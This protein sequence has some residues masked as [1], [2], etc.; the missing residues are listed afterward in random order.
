MTRPE[1]MVAKGDA[2]G[3]ITFFPIAP[4]MHGATQWSVMG[5]AF[6]GRTN[7]LMD[8]FDPNEVWRLVEAEKV[9]GLMITGDAMG[10]PLVE[11]LDAGVEYD[12]SSLALL[13]SSAA[14]FSQTVKDHFFDHFENL[15]IIDSIGSSESGNN[16]MAML[17]KGSGS[18]KGGGPTV[19]AGLDAHVFDEDLKPVEP[20]SGV[21]GKIAR[22]GN[23]PIEYYKDPE[24]TAQTFF[25]KDGVR[26]VMPGD[27]ATIEE[28][29][30]ITLL[31]RGSVS[32]NSGGEK[33]YPE[34]V[35]GAIKAHPD[36]YDAVVVGVPDD[37]Y[38]QRVSAVVQAREGSTPTLESIQDTCRQHIA[39]YKIPRELHLVAAIERSPSGK[40]DYRWAKSVAT[41]EA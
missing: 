36:C 14:I 24:K 31:G 2:E 39:G 4:L 27:F 20:G 16:G 35:E 11:A 15:I 38:G 10:R 1:E 5:G 13:V 28:D 30:S 3:G 9:N 21:I 32:I 26:Y 6:V 22:S 25:E 37:R 12:R 17:M 7:V 29:G 19:K 41:G 18:M 40:P 8:R 34:E 23:V 33:I